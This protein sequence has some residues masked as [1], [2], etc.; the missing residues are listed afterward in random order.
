[1]NEDPSLIPRT[2]MK[3]SSVVIDTCH[4]GAAE[5]GVEEPGDWLAASL[6]ELVSS[7]FNERPA[8]RSKVGSNWK[9]HPTSTSVLYMHVYTHHP[10]VNTHNNEQ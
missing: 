1:M 4:P 3:T 2:H 8:S 5:A 7:D 10:Y 9:G 6:A